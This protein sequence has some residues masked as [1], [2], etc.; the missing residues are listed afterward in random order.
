MCC[1]ARAS[2]HLQQ[3]KRLIALCYKVTH[4]DC[5]PHCSDSDRVLETIDHR[6]LPNRLV[7]SLLLENIKPHM[8]DEH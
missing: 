6:G 5:I 8:K 1:E 7:R 4:C 3:D 2:H